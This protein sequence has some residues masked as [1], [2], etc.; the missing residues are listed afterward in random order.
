MIKDEL[1]VS[2]GGVSIIFIFHKTE[3]MI[4]KIILWNAIKKH[5]NGFI[6]IKNKHQ[7]TINV[8]EI[9]GVPLVKKS[10]KHYGLY[11]RF[12]SNA[13]Y[14][15]YY[16]TGI[17]EIIQLLQLVLIQYLK[18]QGFLLHS[19]GI[20]VRNQAVLF[21]GDSGA[22]KT[23]TLEMTRKKYIPIADDS[24]I[25]KKENDQFSCYQTPAFDKVNWIS[26]TSN[27]YELGKIFFIYKNQSFLIEKL[28]A[29]DFFPLL[30]RSLWIKEVIDKKT[31]KLCINLSKRFHESYSLKLKRK[32]GKILINYF[33]N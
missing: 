16:H 4:K 32:D 20:I 5:L 31:A 28:S 25:I 13:E 9:K 11:F 1:S 2:I 15:I 19:S 30:T 24:I 23:T 8:V 27:R 14:E 18:G 26:R 33:E 3:W 6:S 12:I 7:I 22:G 29:L 21:M 17:I 10:H